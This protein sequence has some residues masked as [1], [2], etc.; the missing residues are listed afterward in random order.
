MGRTNRTALVVDSAACLP[1]AFAARPFV[2]VVPMRLIFGERD[3]LDGRDLTTTQF[4]GLL[5]QADVLPTTSAPSPD[6]YLT[7]FREAAQEADSIVCL[8]VSSSFGGS[9]NAAQAAVVEAEGA[10]PGLPVTL[11][12]SGSAA[13]G[14]ALVATEAIRTIED[15]GSHEEV[16]A[17]IRAVVPKVTL[18]AFVDTLFYLWKGGRVPRL[19]HAG[20]SLLQV[21]PLLEMSSGEIRTVGRPRT[22]RRATRRLIEATAARAAC[23]RPVHLSV[24]HADA[25]QDANDLLEDLRD[26]LNCAESFVSEFS[27]VMGAHTGPGLLGVASWVE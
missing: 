24:I 16:V 13:G 27:P 4:Y 22:R 25:E 17:R 10:L 19:A 12:D 26:E 11:A 7:A 1:E 3:Y 2:H 21:K 18:F 9:Y 20:A 8:T 23:G 5:R 6:S 14:E 15:G